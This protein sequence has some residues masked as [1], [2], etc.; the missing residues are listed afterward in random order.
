[1][2]LRSWH[3]FCVPSPSI[4]GDDSENGLWLQGFILRS[5][6]C[7]PAP[8]GGPQGGGAATGRED[9]LG[10]A[11]VR[12]GPGLSP[13]VFSLSSAFWRSQVVLLEGVSL[14]T[15]RP[16]SSVNTQQPLPKVHRALGGSEFWL[17]VQ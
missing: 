16:E 14:A 11:E 5:V 2:S 6:A 13:S 3:G 8:L 17:R 4:K 9:V 12:A 7:G 10:A 1:M 15:D